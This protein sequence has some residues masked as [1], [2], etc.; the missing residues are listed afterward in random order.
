MAGAARDGGGGSGDELF[1]R[2]RG[3]FEGE[4]GFGAD[5]AEGLVFLV[6]VVKMDGGVFSGHGGNLA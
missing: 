4:D 1:E 5:R 2:K 6:L 3:V